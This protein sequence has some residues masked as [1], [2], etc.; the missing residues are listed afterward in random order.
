VQL[1]SDGARIHS[2][3][4]RSGDESLVLAAHAPGVPVQVGR[5]RRHVGHHA[6]AVFDAEVLVLDDGFQHHRLV[7]D[8]D[9]VCLDGQAGLGNGHV[10]PWGPLREPASA[11]RFAD[12]LC[13]VDPVEGQG[14]PEPCR[15]FAA[16][17][18]PVLR[19]HRRARFLTSLDH[20]TRRPL[21]E[22]A[23]RRVGL[24]AGVARPTSVR[25]T[26]EALGARIVAERLLPDHH[27]YR[28]SDLAGLGDRVR[29]WVTTE[30]DALKILPGWIGDAEL[31]VL[32]IEIELAE[33]DALFD[34]IRALVAQRREAVGGEAG[35]ARARPS[36]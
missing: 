5:D 16:L 19:A 30:K 31:S 3:V 10:V 6:V 17:G 21:E 7:R 20:S 13:I 29:D 24:L 18:R 22:L 11:L 33:P 25:R 2:T 8:L 27:A 9:L 12:A 35:A 32:G 4:A 15:A 1:V 36:G 23:G 34:P 28:P 26:L 14:L